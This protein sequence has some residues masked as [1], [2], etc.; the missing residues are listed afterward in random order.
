MKKV[1]FKILGIFFVAIGIIG[2]FVP[3]LP[4]TVFLLIASYFF[5]KVSPELNTWLLQNK[6]LGIYLRNYKEKTGVPLIAKISSISLLWISILYTIFFL[7]QNVYLQIFLFLIAIIVS[8]HILS[9][10]TFKLQS[11]TNDI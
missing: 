3:L 1:V 4:T 9:M 2:I 11:K 6:Y 7:I 5:L 8:I 10:K